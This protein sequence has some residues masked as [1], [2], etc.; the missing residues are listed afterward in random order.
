[1]W[2]VSLSWLLSFKR[3]LNL[4]VIIPLKL[5]TIT[6]YVHRPTH[7]YW[8]PAKRRGIFWPCL[9]VCL[10]NSLSDKFRKSSRRKFIFVHPIHLQGIPVKFVY[11]GHRDKVKV[12]RAKQV[13][14][15]YSRNVKLR[16]AITPVLQNIDEPRS[17]RAAWGFRLRRIEWWDFHLCHVTGSDHAY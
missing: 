7:I 14:N 16:S 10:Y 13:E 6:A 9:S 15:S 8:P 12:T 4:S 5:F 11:E 1:M 2:C 17:L 3:T